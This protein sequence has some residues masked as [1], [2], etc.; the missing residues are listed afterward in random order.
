MSPITVEQ[1]KENGWE[2]TGDPVCPAKK[3]LS[4]KHDDSYDP[5]G[6]ID[7]IVHRYSNCEM[8]A[9]SLPDGTLVNFDPSNMEELNLFEKMIVA[10]EPAY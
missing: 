2:I 8:F 7:L 10:V 5:D 1:L 3:C 9:L 6:T 4:D